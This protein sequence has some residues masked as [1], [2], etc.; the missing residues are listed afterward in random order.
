MSLTKSARL[1]LTGI[2]F[3]LGIS[4]STAQ[5]AAFNMDVTEG[6]SPLTIRFTNQSTGSGLNYFWDFGN[7]NTSTQ[8]DP[9]AIF[10]ANGNYTVKLKVWNTQGAD[11]MIKTGAIQVY[12]PAQANF[13]LKSA[14][15]GCAPTSVEFQDQSTTG[16]NAIISYLYDFGDGQI[17]S[18]K[19][20][21]HVYNQSG[22]YPVSLEV[23]DSKGCKNV[24][25]KSGFVKINPA[26]NLNYTVS[27]PYSCSPPLTTTFHPVLSGNTSNYTYSWDFGDGGKSNQANPTHTFT[28]NGGFT[29]SLEVR[30]A[31]GCQVNISK[32][33]VNTTV[34]KA[35][36]TA[37]KI[38]GCSPL[39][40]HL[41][42]AS[43]A[44]DPNSIISWNVAGISSHNKDTTIEITQPG[45]YYVTWV[46]YS[47]ACSDT[48]ISQQPL[49]VLPSPDYTFHA[50]DSMICEVS[51]EVTFN[52]SYLNAKRYFW[53]FGNGDTSYAEFPKTYYSDSAKQ[54]TVSLE[55]TDA[56]GC[57][58]TLTKSAYIQKLTSTV[59]I[60]NDSSSSHCLPATA[61]FHAIGNSM[62]NILS[63][64][65]NVDSSGQGSGQTIQQSFSTEGR[66]RVCV[67]MTD[68]A[69]CVVNHCINYG[70]GFKPNARFDFDSLIGCSNVLQVQFTN[71]SI[72]SSN[73]QI[74]QYRWDFGY[75][76]VNQVPLIY[77]EN[78][79]VYYHI[80]PGKYTVTLTASN[81][82]CQDTWTHDSSITVLGP[83]VQQGIFV[84]PCNPN[85]FVGLDDT[86]GE[87]IKWWDINQG[88][89]LVYNTDSIYRKF[90]QLP[91]EIVFRAHNDQ[92]KCWDSAWYHSSM[93]PVFNAYPGHSEAYCAPATLSYKSNIFNCDSILYE[94]SNG[95]NTKDSSFLVRF[96][97]AGIYW[98]KLTL[99]R[100]GCIKILF[101]SFDVILHGP[102]AKAKANTDSFCIPQW[103]QFI[104][105]TSSD[106]DIILR[107]WK[108]QDMSAF[109]VPSDTSFIRFEEVPYNQKL[110]L[111]GV[112]TVEDK[113]GCVSTFPYTVY[114]S[115][116]K[117]QVSINQ[118]TGCEA[119]KFRLK[120]LN[121][122]KAGIEP[123]RYTW[124]TPLGQ[125]NTQEFLVELPKQQWNTIVLKSE[126]DIGC[127]SYDSFPVY[128]PAGKMDP[129][130]IPS[131]T[132]SHCPP[133]LVSFKDTSHYST[134][135]IVAWH[136]EFS[137]GSEAFVQHP[138]K[139]F[140]APGNYTVRLTTTDAVGCT[141]SAEWKDLI[142]IGGPPVSTQFTPL[143]HCD[144]GSVHFT[145]NS[146]TS[147]TIDWD[148]G[149]GTLGYGNTA[150]HFYSKPG[151]YVPQVIV[152]S[153]DGCKYAKPTGDT[154][155]IHALPQF[156][157]DDDGS[158][159][160]FDRVVK[161]K[162][163]HAEAPIQSYH[164]TYPKTNKTGNDSLFTLFIAK[165]GMEQISLR[166]VDTF[167]CANDAKFDIEVPGIRLTASTSDSLLCVMDT[168]KVHLQVTTSFDSLNQ[169]YW[170]SSK[171]NF[172]PT[173]YPEFGQ[174]FQG[175]GKHQVCLVAISDRGC[176]DTIQGPLFIVGDTIPPSNPK[177]HRVWIDP[178][179]QFVAEFSPSHDD[180]FYRYII[181]YGPA[182]APFSHQERIYNL[183][184]T[185][186][187][188]PLL[189]TRHQSYLYRVMQ[190]NACEIS[191]DTSFSSAHQSIELVAIPD[192][193]KV[194]LGWNSYAGWDP[195]KY[196]IE[197]E[198]HAGSGVFES[199]GSGKAVGFPNFYIDSKT[200]CYQN[201]SY[202]IRA[203]NDSLGLWSTSDT[204]QAKPIHVNLLNG[205]P[206][207]RVSVENDAF[208]RCEWTDTT[209]HHYSIDAYSLQFSR[210]GLNYRDMSGWMKNNYWNTST[211]PVDDQVHYFRIIM[212]DSCGDISP[213]GPESR[214]ILL[215]TELDSEE[216]PVLNWSSYLGWE[217]AP[218]FYHI[219]RLENGFYIPVK[220]VGPSDTVFKDDRSPQTGLSSYCYR[221]TAILNT[222]N[223]EIL[224][225]SNESCAP[226]K[227]W[228]FVPN[229]F[230]P[231]GDGLNETFKPSAKYVYN[232]RM[233][234]YSRWGEKLF[235]TY[236]L[237]KGWNTY[238]KGKECPSGVY[239]YL[240][241]ALGADGQ[242]YHLTGTVTVIR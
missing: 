30:D 94:F 112:Y 66:H 117:P 41:K 22:N 52:S 61:Q 214:S 107:K 119:V 200:R 69:G 47:P 23:T 154:V 136:W 14:P 20:P 203:V 9:G 192:T 101:D 146:D 162:N 172:T 180:A 34:P 1:L 44:P 45:S 220:D 181:E 195:E 12:A 125:A 236:D 13:T 40:V 174:V 25:Y 32:Q 228:I 64:T 135:P 122:G 153:K 65:W 149:D 37:D 114:P 35:K 133:L 187:K 215:K 67:K 53:T 29:V 48:L 33:A 91:W 128:S 177:V 178:S 70:T 224:S 242:I 96:D 179:M 105:L 156:E 97:T 68:D 21:S 142:Q 77:A 171:N 8:K 198:T 216:Y 227:S 232:Y 76:K 199:I 166:L 17:S 104:D 233:Q 86:R 155:Y 206:L 50:S 240:I 138:Q 184:D 223:G 132:L 26:F 226:V 208:I 31:A 129:G 158:C 193:N 108:F 15:N 16:N 110:G 197:R 190:E 170:S 102:K 109:T 10:T 123:I 72:D 185:N 82:G 213:A 160:G 159:A 43:I 11:S 92:T 176:T 165:P 225:H 218:D 6:C 7:G 36:F 46:V 28:G 99:Y 150:V 182:S 80:P 143:H 73:C 59:I 60:Q 131:A 134:D 194:F 120:I 115:K 89:E 202:R 81:N 211:L 147:N 219:E 55:I 54:Y 18:Q 98:R 234:I 27:N 157:M 74:D 145:A 4:I 238:Y 24:M 118:E 141:S 144:S 85:E 124:H 84:D 38:S 183:M 49:I 175:S 126:D 221:I 88:D 209:S 163:Y 137:D 188:N 42:D 230:T 148:F 140:I 56:N 169:V 205:I 239:M 79:K 167:G 63:Y 83:Y 58:S 204:A 191:S 71:H 111:P 78:P 189:D 186:W 75:I 57:V 207:L 151:R 39:R 3:Y 116:P 168:A 241:D 235:E 152:Q 231:N 161:V 210:D 237:N 87:T 130:F 100:Q 212:R 113:Y 127:T 164:W 217:S 201:E 19:N 222:A 90:N 93:P 95:F 103:I 139:N 196:L 229:V 106:A 121:L 5:T 173:D 2:L 51:K 62:G